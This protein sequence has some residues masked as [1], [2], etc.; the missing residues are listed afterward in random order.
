MQGERSSGQ[1]EGVVLLLNEE[2]IRKIIPHRGT[3][4]LID[5]VE[6]TELGRRGFGRLNVSHLDLSGHF[7]EAQVVPGFT[8][9]EA[10]AQTLGVVA[11]SGNLINMEHKTP[12]LTGADGLKFRRTVYPNSSVLLEVEV[13]Q[14]RTKLGITVVG[15]FGK[16]ILDNSETA[17]EGKITFVLIDKPQEV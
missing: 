12:R 5:Y 8:L 15:G 13:K 3:S 10:M 1:D 2:E 9:T 11:V 4:L 7:P 16:A 6:I 14:I 17:A